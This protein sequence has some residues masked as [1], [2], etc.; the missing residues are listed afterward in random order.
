MINDELR[1]MAQAI[2]TVMQPDHIYLFGSFA[3]G[4][5]RPD[6][7]YDLYIVV[8]DDAGSPLE[9]CQRAYDAVR[10]LKKR[11]A[12]ITVK[13]ASVFAERTQHNTLERT[14]LQEG[15]EL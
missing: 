12:D 11:R 7:D 9:L 1:A 10:G 6:S 3:K 8:P 4:T 15:I 13:H 14:V 5:A 2:R